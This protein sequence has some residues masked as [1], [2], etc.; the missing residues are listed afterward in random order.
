MVFYFSTVYYKTH[1]EE[2]NILQVS[3]LA[4]ILQY[5]QLVCHLKDS[6]FGLL[7]SSA[8]SEGQ[9][10]LAVFQKA[11]VLTKGKKQLALCYYNLI[12]E[13]Q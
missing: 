8:S 12:L 11:T 4:V 6:L 10:N 1:Q 2:S 9:N 7:K 5:K 3:I 13:F